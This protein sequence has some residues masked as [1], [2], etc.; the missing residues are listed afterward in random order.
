MAISFHCES[1][2]KKIKAPDA[3]G[4]KWG[5]CPYCN[6][7]CYIPLPKADDEPELKLAP[8]D[9]QEETKM[10]SLMQETY[11]L[12][13]QILKERQPLADDPKDQSYAGKAAEKTVEKEVIKQCILYLRQII[14]GDLVPAEKTLEALKRNR[15]AALRVLGA[16]SRA[17][18]PEPELSDIRDTVLQG[19]IRDASAKLS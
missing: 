13:H 18:R 5:K 7:R 2:K 16:M 12:T 3:T 11:S 9:D 10:G 14:D 15:K 19:L 4:G 8:I 17:E 1:C 6:H